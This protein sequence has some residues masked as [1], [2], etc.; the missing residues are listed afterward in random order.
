ML[1]APSNEHYS[2]TRQ[3]WGVWLFQVRI[4][5]VAW[6]LCVCSID[7]TAYAD[8]ELK[9]T[10]ALHIVLLDVS[11]DQM[12]QYIDLAKR[13][14]FNTIVLGIGWR[15]SLDL[16][17]VPW[18]STSGWNRQQLTEIVNY[19]R[20]NDLELVPHIPLLT[21]QHI[22]L[23]QYDKSLLFD[24]KTYD[25][26]NPRVYEVIFPIIDEIISIFQPKALHI[27]H[28]ELM[29]STQRQN[30]DLVSKKLLPWELFVKDVDVLHDF[31]RKRGVQTWMWGDM[32]LSG[33]ELPSMRRAALLGD[34][35]GYG[36]NIRKRIPKDI[37]ICDWHYRDIGVNFG[38]I[39][40]LVN[41]GFSVIG[42]TWKEDRNI[43]DFSDYAA[44]HG[45]SG[46]MATLWQYARS[47]RDRDLADHIIEFSGRV[48][49][50][51]FPDG[52]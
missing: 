46:M 20:Q 51:E 44:K 23:G 48:F 40:L 2:E 34:A 47:A 14:G 18:G 27:G 38:S 1:N 35:P 16:K 45:A 28:D 11:V 36:A 39:D 33:Q 8:V 42:V 25:P 17:S 7:A 43:A 12:K 24:E 15:K 49:A 41:D 5:I 13:S 50:K 52:D 29:G 4:L 30:N 21:K 19:A 9:P 26:N 32:L 37:V 10:R 31:L 6:A 22:F 3:N